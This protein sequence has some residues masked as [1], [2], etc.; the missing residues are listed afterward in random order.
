[1]ASKSGG[2]SGGRAT[3]ASFVERG[4]GGR[5]VLSAQGRNRLSTLTSAREQTAKEIR[6]L[7]T[8]IRSARRSGSERQVSKL[9][10]RRE[11]LLTRQN[12]FER[13]ERRLRSRLG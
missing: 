10:S 7:D 4:F 12:T 6:G 11:R 5:T 8:R 13:A 1:M 3:A 2:S 9:V